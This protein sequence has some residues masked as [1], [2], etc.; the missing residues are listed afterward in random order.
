MRVGSIKKF[1]VANGPGIRTSVFVTGCSNRCEGCF[2]A[3][4][5]DYSAGEIWNEEKEN[6]VLQFLQDDKVNGLS[7]LG[8]EPLEQDE[9]LEKLVKKV[10]QQT[11]KSIWL[12]TG[13][14]YENLN[15]K[16]KAVIENV[17]VLIDGPFEINRKDHR[18]KY[19]GST[20]QRVIDLNLTR[21]TGK[22]S[23]IKDA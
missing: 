19:C 5:Q 17:D 16:Q 11:K 13:F 14:T 1:D 6:L 8:G 15:E 3:E 12:W 2:N 23:L 20:N 21:K 7:I 22:L 18:L 9:N 10:K 4:Y